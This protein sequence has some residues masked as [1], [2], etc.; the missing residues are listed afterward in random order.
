M[1]GQESHWESEEAL[2]TGITIFV[3][4]CCVMT[5]IRKEENRYIKEK[6]CG[7]KTNKQTNNSIN[8]EISTP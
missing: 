4:T 6:Y 8:I 2:P 3:N 1:A 7:T 5:Q